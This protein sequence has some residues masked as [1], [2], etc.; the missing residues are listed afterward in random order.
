MGHP[1]QKFRRA[2]MIGFQPEQLQV[3]RTEEVVENTDVGVE[4]DVDGFYA[5]CLQMF[6]KCKI[7]S[8]YAPGMNPLL[9]S[10][11]SYKEDSVMKAFK[12]TGVYVS[13]R[14]QAAY[15]NLP[16]TTTPITYD[17]P[18]VYP[19]TPDSMISLP[20]FSSNTSAKPKAS[21]RRPIDMGM[22]ALLP[23]ANSLSKIN[24]KKVC[25]KQDR[26]RLWLHLNGLR[27]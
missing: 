8:D 11:S 20:T 10:Y 25:E 23:T 19:E 1:S 13:T 21:M 6:S 22:L 12:Q 2:A 24:K 14:Q 16:A 27:L 9:G 4:L 7:S 18:K 26:E 3:P 17:S 15:K 5:S